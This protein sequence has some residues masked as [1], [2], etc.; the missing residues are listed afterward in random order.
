MRV[1]VVHAAAVVA[2]LVYLLASGK[3]AT[4]KDDWA[5]NVVFLTGC[6]TILLISLV[7]LTTWRRLGAGLRA[8]N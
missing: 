4:L 8:A 3:L 5:A 7:S 6:V 1:T 2:A